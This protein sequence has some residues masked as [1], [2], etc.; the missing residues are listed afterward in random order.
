MALH[1]SRV[2]SVFCSLTSMVLPNPVPA[3]GYTDTTGRPLPGGAALP[4]VTDGERRKLLEEWNNTKAEYPH[5]LCVHQ[6]LEAQA[7]R[8][9]ESVAV[10]CRD[11]QLT[12]GELNA[13]ANRLA[14]YLVK[15]G[16]GAEVPVGICLERSL[17]LAVA[18]QGVLK[19][20]GACLPLDPKYPK[21]RLA[22]M[23]EDSKAPVVLIQPSLT[24]E[25]TGATS[26]VVCLSPGLESIAQEP[27]NNLDSGVKPHNLAYAIYT[28]GSTGRP[29][30]VL[31]TH[32]GLVNHHMAA[33]KL[34]G[35]KPSDRVLQF[36]SISF[37][38][39]VEEIF[40][41]WVVGGSVVLWSEGMSLDPSEFLRWIRQQSVTV[42]DLPTAY[43]HELV[44]ALPE[45]EEGL[46][47]SLRLVIVG[48][49]KASADAFR[50]WR[51][52]AG[53]RVRWIN[54]YGPT[55]AS[56]I[57][58]AYEPGKQE[59]LTELPIGRPIANV[60]VYIL[61]SH[62]QPVPIGVHGELYIGG[63]GVARG[64]LNQPELTAEKFVPDPFSSE[65]N[66]RMYKTG[67]LA[68]YRPDGN[69]EFRGRTDHQV[70]IRGYRVELGEIESLLDKHPCVREAVVEVRESASGDKCLV[71]YVVPSST[72]PPTAGDLR[73]F[74]KQTL[75]EYMV[76]SAFVELREMPLTPNG[77]IDRR[78]LP[79]PERSVLWPEE[80]PRAPRDRLESQLV[81]IWEEVLGIRPIGVQQNFFDL[82]GHSLL[83][84]RLVHRVGKAL[85]KNLPIATLLEAPTVERLA[86]FLRQGGSSLRWSSLVPIQTGGSRPAFFCV[87]G[88]GGTV[89]RFH[90]LARHLGADQPVYG[91]QAQG[92]DPALPCHNTVEDMTTHYLMEVRSVQPQGPYY[93]G[94]YSFGG[95]V[96]IE[97]ARQLLREG[98]EPRVVALF[99]TF[100]GKPKSNASLFVKFLRKP[101]R[102]WLPYLRRK[103]RVHVQWYI[104]RLWF[105]RR[106]V[107]VRDACLQAEESYVPRV[108]PGRLVLFK[109][110]EKSL[111]SYQESHGGWDQWA[112][113][114]V[115]IHEI[116]GDHGSITKEPKVRLLAQE[117]R[118]CFER[119][120]AACPPSVGL[121]PMEGTEASPSA[122]R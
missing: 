68:Q 54:T 89:M 26:Q 103:A 90:A 86:G 71:A 107:E 83:A 36:S 119:A 48:G 20:G 115:E 97:M 93:F 55:E 34:Y 1:P 27:Q 43:W 88:L 75:P 94:G 16:V 105:P 57:A 67:D 111:R 87:H 2:C 51:K 37:D 72:P 65:P 66:A 79:A 29:K 56:V 45:L 8:T 18:L 112:A 113:G 70:K 95:L 120:Q 12:Y 35:L 13:R 53:E 5:D 49:E 82:G 100:P 23:Q 84:V 76:P 25:F 114:G 102:Q 15:R 30:G 44:Y 98:E 122:R 31:L 64:Y 58:T 6:L 38:I 63:D 41:T 101:M 46:P 78:A 4:L 77:K 59:M 117:L 52:C 81:A 69:I 80:E 9:P 14:H 73:A 32:R 19:A 33:V 17:E 24:S 11:Q 21:E 3:E 10:V 108:Y 104:N 61:D 28:S 109:P 91:L 7:E 118:A 116:A 121:G 96:A 110:T 60:R 74:V 106:I 47:V 42:L 99:D 50:S 92:L 62:Q 85:G 40:P 39:A 22:Y